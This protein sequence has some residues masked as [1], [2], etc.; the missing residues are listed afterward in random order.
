MVANVF[1]FCGLFILLTQILLI[2]KLKRFLYVKDYIKKY[3][4][5]TNKLPEKEEF[6]KDD[7]ETYSFAKV[8]VAMTS[9]WYFFGLIG[10]NWL[11]FVFFFI[12]NFLTNILLNR[13]NNK[14]FNV[15]IDSSRWIVNLI[16]TAI[17]VFNHFHLH[18][19]LTKFIFG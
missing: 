6:S 8:T 5:V 13:I 7:F 16:L 12:I 17:L 4:K 3:V 18:I 15:A 11:I 14:L 1:Y 19:N 2:S 9:L 10:Q